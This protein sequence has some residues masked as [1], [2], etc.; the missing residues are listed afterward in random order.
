MRDH[1][2]LQHGTQYFAALNLANVARVH[3]LVFPLPLMLHLRCWHCA[4]AAIGPAGCV[5]ECGEGAGYAPTML[6][7]CSRCAPAVSCDSVSCE[8]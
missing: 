6:P 7:L 4:A 8:Q 2:H 5:H 1:K 3:F